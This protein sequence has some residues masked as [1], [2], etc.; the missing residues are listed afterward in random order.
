MPVIRK[1]VPSKSKINKQTNKQTNPPDLD[2]QLFS[3]VVSR[4]RHV[5]MGQAQ[6]KSRRTRMK[7][8]SVF[9]PP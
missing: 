2:P 1:N 6:L 7:T 9:P 5:R 3:Y 8:T 4:G